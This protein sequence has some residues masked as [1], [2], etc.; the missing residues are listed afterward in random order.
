MLVLSRRTA[1]SVFI[2]S[3]IQVTILAIKGGRVQLGFQAPRDVKICR[4]ELLSWE[5]AFQVETP[6]GDTCK[7][8]A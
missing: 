3:D 2:G 4:E 5:R 7:S 8:G 6:T 1:E